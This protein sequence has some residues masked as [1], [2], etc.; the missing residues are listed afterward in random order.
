MTFIFKPSMPVSSTLSAADTSKPFR[1]P[2]P[3][4]LSNSSYYTKVS[5]PRLHS[6]RSFLASRI[7]KNSIKPLGIAPDCCQPSERDIST[8]NTFVN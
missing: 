2:T 8:A 7:L 3:E 5:F 4:V 1:A 6:L